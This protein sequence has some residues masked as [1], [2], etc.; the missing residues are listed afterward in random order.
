MGAL[1]SYSGDFRDF[2]IQG[3]KLL[4]KILRGAKPAD[5]PIE[6]PDRLLLAINITTAK[7][8]GI[9]IPRKVLSRADRLVE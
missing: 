8:I 9:N 1:A 7:D 4:A 6:T 2:G 5:I 3:A